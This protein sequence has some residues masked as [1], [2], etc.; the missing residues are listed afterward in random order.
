VLR[1]TQSIFPLS[2]LLFTA[3]HEDSPRQT[4]IHRATRGFTAFQCCNYISVYILCF[5]PPIFTEFTKVAGNGND[6]FLILFHRVTTM[7]FLS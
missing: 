3:P 2:D 5:I 4:R 1:A 7:W 6:P